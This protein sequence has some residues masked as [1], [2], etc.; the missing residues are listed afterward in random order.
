MP[1]I[2]DA[3]CFDTTKT[4]FC[5]CN[6]TTKIWNVT[7][8]VWTAHCSNSFKCTATLVSP[9][10]ANIKNIGTKICAEKLHMYDWIAWSV[11]KSA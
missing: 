7:W 2:T 9:S 6:F 10:M 3:F 11:T 5:Q 8:E 1:S 4:R